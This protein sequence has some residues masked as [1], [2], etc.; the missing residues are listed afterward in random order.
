MATP[1]LTAELFQLKYAQS[2]DT[3]FLVHPNHAPRKLTRTSDTAWTLTEV[4]FE[5]GPFLDENTTDTTITSSARTGTVTL[6]AS[7]DLFVSTDVGRLVKIYDGFAKISAFTN[8]TTVAAVVQPNLDGLS[9]LLPEYTA[10]TISFAEGDPSSTGSE[11]NDRIVDSAK[12]F[13]DQGFVVGQKLR[14][15]VQAAPTT[16]TS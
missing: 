11:H 10:T 2:A 8:A 6:T 9:E 14:S 12:L 3:M 1:Y 16:A 5:F 7:A 13:K 4:P 15:A